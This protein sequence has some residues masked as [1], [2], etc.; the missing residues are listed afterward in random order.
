MVINNIY[1]LPKKFKDNQQ[2]SLIGNNLEGS[3]TEE[4]LNSYEHG[5]NSCQNKVTYSGTPGICDNQMMI[6]SELIGNYER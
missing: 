6:Q 1:K 2:P 4:S 3:T 5:G